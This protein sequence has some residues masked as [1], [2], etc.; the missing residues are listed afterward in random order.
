MSAL[1]AHALIL[2]V[3]IAFSFGIFQWKTLSSPGRRRFVWGGIVFLF[4]GGL[5][6]VAAFP[7]HDVAFV[8]KMKFSLANMWEFSSFTV[9]EAFTGEGKS[10]C[11]VLGISLPFLWRGRGLVVFVT[12]CV[13]VCVFGAVVYAAVWHQGI[14]LLAWL[15]ALWIS[16]DH[17]RE[18]VPRKQDKLYE[19]LAMSALASVA[20]VQCYWTVKSVSY[21][22]KYPYSAGRSAAR[23]LLNS[24]IASEELCGV[25]YATTAVQPYFLKGPFRGGTT[26]WDWSNSNPANDPGRVFASG[27]RYVLVS[28]KTSRDRDDWATLTQ[29]IGYHPVEHFE[30]NL[31]W[32]TKTLEAESFDL[33]RLNDGDSQRLKPSSTIQM[34]DTSTAAQLISGFY[35]LEANAWRWTGKDFSV[36]LRTP[37]EAQSNGATVTIKVFVSEK[38]IKELGTIT[39]RASIGSK[40]LA[41]RTFSRAGVFE[42]SVDIPANQAHKPLIWIKYGLDKSTGPSLTDPRELGLVVT[43]I[44]ADAKKPH[45]S[46]R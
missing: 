39:L 16:A 11:L 44:R 3:C 45:I 15:F 37:D 4:I 27:C 8:S 30:G 1:S 42:Y 41:P 5:C 21:D 12:S 25:G 36:L 34:N 33:Y 31:F 40:E 17:Q 19:V 20:L 43:S 18:A 13:V 29:L 10:T 38:Q 22:W 28:Y 6:S 14:L 24:R 7:A 2:S 32:K 35:R 26:Y 46:N 9:R 23:F